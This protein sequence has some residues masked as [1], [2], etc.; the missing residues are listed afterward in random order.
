MSGNEN[1][2]VFTDDNWSRSNYY[3]PNI[4]SNNAPST[5]YV[6]PLRCRDY[7]KVPWFRRAI[8]F[9]MNSDPDELR[10][11]RYENHARF[12]AQDRLYSRLFQS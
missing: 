7:K 2:P 3:I 5:M 8:R 9:L 10:C 12:G 1:F 6:C 11:Y 4:G